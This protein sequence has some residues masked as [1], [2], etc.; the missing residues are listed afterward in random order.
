MPTDQ[1]PEDEPI[2]TSWNPDLGVT[3]IGDPQLE[4]VHF[5]DRH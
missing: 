3:G 2:D 1:Q 4:E 5:E